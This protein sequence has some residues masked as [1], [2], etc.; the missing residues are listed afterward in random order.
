[1][2]RY[3]VERTFPQGLEIP[4][5][6]AGAEQCRGVV[7]R[8]ADVAVTW[9]H[10]YVS[11]DENDQSCPGRDSNPHGACAPVD[12]KSPASAV[13]PPGPRMAERERPRRSPLMT[14]IKRIGTINWT[15]APRGGNMRSPE[16][17]VRNSEFCP[18]GGHP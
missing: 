17:Q 10:S 18:T 15:M 12:F 16:R 4:A 9:L 11:A 6:P 14:P 5:T 3:V 13:S 8:N 7:E 1:M 2:P